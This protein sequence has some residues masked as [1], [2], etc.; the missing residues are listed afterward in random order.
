MGSMQSKMKL[1]I[2]MHLMQPSETNW[3][4]HNRIVAK[5]VDTLILS[6]YPL[7]STSDLQIVGEFISEPSHDVV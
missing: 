4:R 1:S 2:S 6:L 3:T 5:M 7:M